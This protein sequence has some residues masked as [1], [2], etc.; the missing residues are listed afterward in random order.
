MGFQPKRNGEQITCS[1]PTWRS[2]VYREA[3]L[4]EEI[5]RVYGY[6]KIPT[7]NKITIEVSPTD[8]RKKT[9]DAIGTYLTGCGFYETVTISFIDSRDAELFAQNE[10]KQ[11]L[12]VKDVTRTGTN[13][14][15]KAFCL[16][17]LA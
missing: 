1:V 2:D 12:S 14:L 6:D 10:D 4:I 16:R 3:D 8:T 15:G 17:C 11:H 9:I 5:A 7:E 13:L